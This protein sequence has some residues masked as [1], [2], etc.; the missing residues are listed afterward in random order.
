MG[1]AG[2]S[3]NKEE[4]MA[5]SYKTNTKLEKY[6]HHVKYRPHARDPPL[7]RPWGTNSFVPKRSNNGITLEKKI[8]VE[9]IEA[10]FNGNL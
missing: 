6:R 4:S 7:E 10:T 3:S 8:N 5:A 2:S 9:K 1:A